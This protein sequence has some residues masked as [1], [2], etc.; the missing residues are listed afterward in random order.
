M[1][2]IL[3]VDDSGIIRMQLKKMLEELG[4]EVVGLAENGQEGYDLYKE[5]QPDAV[6][7]DI[8]MPVLNGLGAVEKIVDEFPDAAIIMVS[9]IDDRSITYD[10]IG[11]G[12]LDFINKPIQI[13]ELQVKLEIAL[14]D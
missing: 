13:D 2:K 4:H 10:C 6:T 3:V 14:E 8:N 12:A 11:A 7:M 5:K 9:S 1:A